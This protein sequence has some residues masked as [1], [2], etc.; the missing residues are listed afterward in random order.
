MDES[1]ASLKD[2]VSLPQSKSVILGSVAIIRPRSECGS[3]VIVLHLQDYGDTA[4]ASRR[5]W[6]HV[7]PNRHDIGDVK[8]LTVSRPEMSVGGCVYCTSIHR[9]SY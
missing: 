8:F 3:N 6:R 5:N 9:P 4:A 1:R 7:K 2:R